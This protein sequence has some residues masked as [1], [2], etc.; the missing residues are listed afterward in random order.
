MSVAAF[1]SVPDHADIT[2]DGKFFGTTLSSLRLA[3]GDYSVTMEK[4]NFKPWQRI[5]T[6]GIG[7]DVSLDVTL[8]ELP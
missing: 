3:S 6:V 4:S 1:A 2:V 7:G 5:M 8:E